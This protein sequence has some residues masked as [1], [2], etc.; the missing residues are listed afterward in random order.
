VPIS[1]ITLNGALTRAASLQSVGC[2]AG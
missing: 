2:C 1:D